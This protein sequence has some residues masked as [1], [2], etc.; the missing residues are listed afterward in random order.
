MVQC[1]D[2]P[3]QV[4]HF[5][6][7]WTFSKTIR[8]YPFQMAPPASEYRPSTRSTETTERQ[9]LKYFFEFVWVATHDS[10]YSQVV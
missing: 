1:R 6:L 4:Q 5:F 8:V 10:L 9:F 2:D 7:H 3:G